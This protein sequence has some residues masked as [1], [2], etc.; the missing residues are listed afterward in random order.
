MLPPVERTIADEFER[1]MDVRIVGVTADSLE[2]VRTADNARF[3]LSL[4]KL[5]KADRDFAGSLLKKIELSRPL[6]DTPWLRSVR[7]DFEIFDATKKRLMPLPADAY[8]GHPIFVVAFNY[9]HDPATAFPSGARRKDAVEDQAPVLW[10]MLSGEPALFELAGENLPKDHAIISHEARQKAQNQGDAAYQEYFTAWYNRN[11]RDGNLM[12]QF[13]PSEKERADL[14]FKLSK[15]MPPYWADVSV[16]FSLGGNGS[17]S[18]PQFYA[19][20]RDGTPV[21]FRGT[22]LAGTRQVVMKVLR[23]NATELE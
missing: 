16:S 19:V 17:R 8:A 2:V 7:R 18:F 14:V 11:S 21:K 13:N 10:I 20:R 12:P 15:A 5:S 22:H 1:T 23:D 3:T 9:L 6:P 4:A